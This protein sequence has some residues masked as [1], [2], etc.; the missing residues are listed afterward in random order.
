[1]NVLYSLKGFRK[2]FLGTDAELFD[3]IK[4]MEVNMQET[5]LPTYIYHHENMDSIT[6]QMFVST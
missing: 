1:M 4:N 6:N 3:R 5:Q 2:I